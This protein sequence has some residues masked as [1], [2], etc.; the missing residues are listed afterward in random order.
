MVSIRTSTHSRIIWMIM[1]ASIQTT[2]ATAKTNP[3]VYRL[4]C[5][6]FTV[7][8]TVSRSHWVIRIF[9]RAIR[10]WMP[11]F[12]AR[13]HRKRNTR[14]CLLWSRRVDCRWKCAYGI[15]LI[16]RWGIWNRLRMLRSFR[17]WFCRCCGRKL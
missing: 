9:I 11:A 1:V 4:V 13:I 2:L 12:W 14:V 5:S 6:T 10:R 15:R 17:I 8:T 3:I 7:A 16:W